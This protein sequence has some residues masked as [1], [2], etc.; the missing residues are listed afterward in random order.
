MK[1]KQLI[2]V[3]K[4]I[5]TLSFS[6]TEMDVLVEIESGSTIKYEYKKG[7]IVCDSV[8]NKVRIID[9]L[10]YPFNY[11][12][13]INSSKQKD[14]DYLD[15]VLIGNRISSGDTLSGRVICMIE[16]IDNDE[17]DN[18]V[19]LED[20]DPNS[21]FIPLI[22]INGIK[23]NGISPWHRRTYGICRDYC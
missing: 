22:H 11:G 12:F 20:F 21:E 15:A 16:T 9:Y 14:N 1:I 8:E 4:L 10:N 5:S 3:F 23:L 7:A 19:D 2:L 6:Q 17:E 18:K 13:I